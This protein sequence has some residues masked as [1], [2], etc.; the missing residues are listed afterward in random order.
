MS[1][2][3]KKQSTAVLVNI[4][5]ELYTIFDSFSRF[6]TLK[7]K[8]ERRDRVLEDLKHIITKDLNYADITKEDI[9][10]LFKV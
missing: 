1:K 2:L 10:D 6:K 8:G 9:F 7:D 5:H 4:Y 3:T